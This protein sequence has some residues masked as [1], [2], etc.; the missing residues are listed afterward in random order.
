MLMRVHLLIRKQRDAVTV[1]CDAARE[2]YNSFNSA[3]STS[4]RSSIFISASG[5]REGL[6]AKN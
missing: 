3:S 4:S 2:T 1:L 6:K 5:G